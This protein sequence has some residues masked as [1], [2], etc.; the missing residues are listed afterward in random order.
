MVAAEIR[1]TGPV[2]GD[3]IPSSRRFAILAARRGAAGPA[4]A[5]FWSAARVAGYAAG[6]LS[7]ARRRYFAEPA[8]EV[9]D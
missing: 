9:K 1:V 7:R 8:R 2:F 6:R 4:L 3:R 5:N